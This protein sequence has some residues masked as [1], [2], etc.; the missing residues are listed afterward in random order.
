MTDNDYAIKIY[1]QVF[2]VNTD[3]GDAHVH[4]I[5][6]AVRTLEARE[7]AALEGYFRHGHSY[8]QTGE[9]I[10]G[11]RAESARRVVCKALLKLRH[12]HRAQGMSVS[13]IIQHRNKLLDEAAD[14]IDWLLDQVERLVQGI[15]ID[16]GLAFQL[17]SRKKSVADLGL[18]SRVYNHL[19]ASGLRTV[20]ALLELDSLAILTKRSNF[21]QKSY[22]EVLSKMRELGHGEWADRVEKTGK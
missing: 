15:A 5:L 7:Q 2:R 8:K 22:E 19:I 10:G 9:M 17:E 6:A 11:I 20:E 4:G 13:A 1:C 14:K 21:G 16:E 3:H 18:P 12:P